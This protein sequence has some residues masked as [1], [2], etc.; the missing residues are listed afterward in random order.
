MTTRKHHDEDI[1][2]GG[3]RESSVLMAYVFILVFLQLILSATIFY[4]VKTNF[5][6]ISNNSSE[7]QRILGAQKLYE[8]SPK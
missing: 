6:Q 7:I 3:S 8:R 5:F 1:L 4:Y 2:E